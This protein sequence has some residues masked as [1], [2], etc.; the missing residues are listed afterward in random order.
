[1][2][3]EGLRWWSLATV[4]PLAIAGPPKAGTAG[5]IAVLPFT[6]ETESDLP[7]CVGAELPPATEGV[8][9]GGVN[10]FLVAFA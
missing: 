9:E 6:G 2:V 10:D 7:C 5:G 3:T 4:L 8:D 1:M